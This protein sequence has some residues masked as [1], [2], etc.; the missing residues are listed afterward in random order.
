MLKDLKIDFPAV[1]ALNIFVTFA[2]VIIASGFIKL[3]IDPALVQVLTN[4]VLLMVGFY[5]GSSKDSQKKTDAIIA[6]SPPPPVTESK[7]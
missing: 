6:N 1:L 5:F 3:P 2:I 7:P 4:I